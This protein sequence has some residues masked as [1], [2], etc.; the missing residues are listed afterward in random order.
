MGVLH[1]PAFLHFCLEDLTTE[2]KDDILKYF[3]KYM[4]Y[5]DD[6]Q[7]RLVAKEILE[8]RRQVDLEAVDLTLKCD[9]DDCCS[10]KDDNLPVFIEDLL[11][12]TTPSDEKRCTRLLLRGEFG[13]QL[14]HKLVLRAATLEAALI[15]ALMSSKGATTSLHQHFDNQFVNEGLRKYTSVLLQGKE[16]TFGLLLLMPPPPLLKCGT[17]TQQGVAGGGTSPGS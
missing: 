12:G 3:L 7:T 15:G 2:I 9:D 1:L 4:R 16:P 10:Q 5:L 13:K 6:L 8:L 14:L 11:G 17:R